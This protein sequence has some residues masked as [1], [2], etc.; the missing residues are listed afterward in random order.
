MTTVMEFERLNIFLKNK[1]INERNSLEEN[2]LEL[3]RDALFSIAK[4]VVN[5]FAELPVISPVICRPRQNKRTK[6]K[7]TKNKQ[8]KTKEKHVIS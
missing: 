6:K 8:N 2:W 3:K 1:Y 5:V 4:A 7:Q